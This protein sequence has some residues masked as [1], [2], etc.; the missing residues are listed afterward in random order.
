MASVHEAGS[1]PGASTRSRCCS[2]RPP[3]IGRISAPPRA[4]A[5]GRRSSRTFFLRGEDLER[6]GRVGRRQ[7]H[8]GEDLGHL[9]GHR[10]ADLA[11]RRDHAA[12]RADRVRGVR[13]AVGLGDVGADRDPARVGVLDDRDAGEVAVVVRRPPRGVGVDVVVVRHLLAVQ[14]LG[15][16]QPA[17]RPRGVQRG[18]PGAGSRRS[19]ASPRAPRSR[20]PRRGTGRRAL[21][22][23]HA[24]HPRGDGDVV[25]GGVPERRRGEPAPVGRA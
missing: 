1:S 23:E 2:S 10:R 3:E 22:R 25:G 19:A 20:R 21:G 24:A 15:A 12:E 9:L 7:H 16:G 11:V 6:L 17:P 4:P 13:L 8:L 5:P 14:L 18:A